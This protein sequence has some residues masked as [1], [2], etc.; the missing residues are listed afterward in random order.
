MLIGVD[1]AGKG[2][3]LGPMV[4]AGIACE[5]EQ[6]LTPFG[7]RDSKTLTPKKREEIFEGLTQ[8]FPYHCIVISASEIDSLRKMM[9]MNVIT[10]KAH[11]MAIKG[12]PKNPAAPCGVY[13]DACD[14][15]E[16]RHGTIISGYV[17]SGYNVVARHRADS[18]FPVVAAA[19][20]VAKVTR[21][22]I[23]DEIK[24]ECEHAWGDIGSGY[25][26]DPKTIKF[27]KAYIN[28]QHKAPYTARSSW[29]T[30]KNMLKELPVTKQPF[31]QKH[32][33]E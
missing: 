12:I 20:I 30:V 1:E 21:D 4:V 6:D 32:L 33:F 3:V 26:S 28:E 7:V 16:S 2:S 10:A 23:I 29:A 15:N 24:L 11:A 27:L 5:N 17:G 8:Q 19:S 13:V 25:P 18:L 9:T 14:V 22:R 31:V